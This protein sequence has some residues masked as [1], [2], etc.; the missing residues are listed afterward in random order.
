ML[1][2]IRSWAATITSITVG[3]V[4][5]L[6]KCGEILDLVFVTLGIVGLILSIRLT[7]K[8]IKKIDDNN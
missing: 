6:Q 7:L 8:K 1:E 2:M 3:A 5:F 4:G